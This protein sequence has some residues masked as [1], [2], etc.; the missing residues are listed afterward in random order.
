[1]ST[2]KE[3]AAN[4][5]V[6]QYTIRLKMRSDLREKW[7]K[8]IAGEWLAI[9]I[10]WHKEHDAELGKLWS[11]WSKARSVVPKDEFPGERRRPQN[12]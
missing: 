6:F 4:N 12:R 2:S 5:A 8:R 9:M 11:D 1:M 10:N 7:L 3:D